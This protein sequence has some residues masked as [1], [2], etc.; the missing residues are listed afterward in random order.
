MDQ[1]GR[2]LYDL[3]EAAPFEWA[4]VAFSKAHLLHHEAAGRVL[5][6]VHVPAGAPAWL[7][8]PGAYL[9]Q[10]LSGPTAPRTREYPA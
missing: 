9:R 10:A 6:P 7:D 1:F 8:Q 2:D 4:A 3:I 5:S